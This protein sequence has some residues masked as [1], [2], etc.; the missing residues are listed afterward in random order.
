VIQPIQQIL[1]TACAGVT[2]VGGNTAKQLA[3]L[4]TARDIVNHAVETIQGL[5][6]DLTNYANRAANG[7]LDSAATAF[8]DTLGLNAVNVE[9]QHFGCSPLLVQASPTCGQMMNDPHQRNHPTSHRQNP[10]PETRAP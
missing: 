2:G 7:L 3:F 1:E 8:G 4:C 6:Q 10:A 5:N 9:L